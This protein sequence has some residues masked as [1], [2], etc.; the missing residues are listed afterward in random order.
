MCISYNMD[1]QTFKLDTEKSSYV[2]KVVKGN[3]ITHLY[4]GARIYS[5]E[6]NEVLF[7]I[8]RGM[9]ANPVEAGNSRSFSLDTLPLEYSGYGIGDFRS[10]ALMIELEDGSNA[11][12]LRY[13][14]HKIYKGKQKLKGLPAVFGTE[15]EV[16]SL[17]LICEDP[18]SK[19]QVVLYYHVFSAFNV[20]TR[21]VV[22]T[23]FH[24]AQV[25]LQRI[26]SMSMDF[27]RNDFDMIH[28]YGRHVS[29]CNYERVKISHGVERVESLRGASSAHHNPFVMLAESGA[30]EFRGE[31]Y[32]YNFVYSGNFLFEAGVDQTETTRVIMG[33]NPTDFSWTLEVGESFTA[34]EVVMTYS[35]EG[36]NQLSAQL[37][38]LYR[39]N[40]CRGSWNKKRRPILI[41]NWEATYFDFNGDKL[42][43]IAKNAKDIGIELLVMDD[44]WFGNREDD[45]SSLGDWY[46]NETKLQGTLGNLVERINKIG[47]KF[48]IWYEPEMISKDSDLYR[49]HEDWCLHVPGRNKTPSRNQLVLD[50][51]RQDV[52]DY[53]YE[54]MCK[55]LSSANIE[56]VKWDMN[57]NITERWSANLS[58]D[59]QK[60]LWHRYILGLY[61]LL[62]RLQESFPQILW[63]GCASGSGR[64]DPGMLYY[65]SQIWT[66][67][68][69][70]AIER[71]KIQS[72][73]SYAYPVSSMGAHVSAVPNHQTCRN[74]SLETRGVVAMSGTFGYELDLTKVTESEKEIMK[75]Q[76]ETYKEN[77][78]LINYGVY[79]R[80]ENPIGNSNFSSWCFS[81]EDKSEI[82]LNCVQIKS[83]PNPPI[84]F[85]KIPAADESH[86]YIEVE[87]GKEYHGSVLKN[88]GYHAILGEFNPKEGAEFINTP[89]GASLM[90]KFII[91]EK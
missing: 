11:T 9:A 46:V 71:I 75:K 7:Q 81:K 65:F 56:Y 59:R 48:G 57:R 70:D 76:V 52:Q 89:D 22:V 72:G 64:F 68:D 84:K 53:L 80:I 90:K 31:C 74:T 4:Y 14:S 35:R 26:M 82:L 37:H 50:M 28:F 24:N 19:I 30:D 5:D 43:E 32:G 58:A 73:T 27:I 23:N 51:S 20:I 36:F 88:V 61:T 8:N 78:D 69:T 49:T 62:E 34:P 40:L 33:L 13:V 12:D 85:I 44:G 38:K 1:N 39:S 79:T 29:E 21:N 66:S 47:L 18:Y 10:S 86:V 83:I 55:V 6:L 54:Q 16:E 3:F 60:E 42:V 63:E 15:E 77:Y 2:M 41:N 45:N 17:E 87:T 25:K 91:K 67:D